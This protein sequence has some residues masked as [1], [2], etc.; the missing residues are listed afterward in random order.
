MEISRVNA[1]K[2]LQVFFSPVPTPY[3]VKL[4]PLAQCRAV[5][6]FTVWTINHDAITKLPTQL[7]NFPHRVY[8]ITTKQKCCGFFISP[9][10]SEWT[11]FHN[12]SK[13]WFIMRFKACGVVLSNKTNFDFFTNFS[14]FS[15]YQ[16]KKNSRGKFLKVG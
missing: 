13:I 5:S 11:F 6:H 16:P 15:K 8:I 12:F 10:K 2:N 4:F 14:K 7:L 9:R 1:R 3:P